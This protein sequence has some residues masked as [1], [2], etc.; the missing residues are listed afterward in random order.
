MEARKKEI[1]KKKVAKIFTR[2]FMVD[3]LYIN[4]T[5]FIYI[6]RKKNSFWFG[7]KLKSIFL[8]FQLTK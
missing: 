4:R 5:T 1:I 3:V 8:K 2:F 6:I 7:E